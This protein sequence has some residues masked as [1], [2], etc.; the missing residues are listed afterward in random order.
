MKNNQKKEGLEDETENWE[1]IRCPSFSIPIYVIQQ[2]RTNTG[3]K[4][5]S[6]RR[7]G[8]PAD[9]LLRFF[10]LCICPTHST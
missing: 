9:Y 2:T 4:T 8:I 3:L 5:G 10:S 7:H 6:K 1:M